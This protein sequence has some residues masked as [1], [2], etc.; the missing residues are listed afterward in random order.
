MSDLNDDPKVVAKREGLTVHLP[1]DNELF[2]DI[3]SDEDLAHYEEMMEVLRSIGCSVTPA[4]EV[5][6]VV[7]SRSK[8][9]KG[10]HIRVRFEQD[11]TPMERI[12]FQAALGSD[13]KRELLSIL[14]IR[15]GVDRPPTIF[16]EPTV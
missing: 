11:V 9:G 15:L 5:D 16:F 12:A 2:I 7:R 13:R 14:R 8:S 3:D 4:I 6:S 10:W 1:D